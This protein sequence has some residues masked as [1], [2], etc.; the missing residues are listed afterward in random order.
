MKRIVLIGLI[1]GLGLSLMAQT[2]EQSSADTATVGSKMIYEVDPDPVIAADL[3]TLEQGITTVED[4]KKLV[5]QEDEWT[6]KGDKAI[7]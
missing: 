2:M 7:Q 5:T 3:N 4:L 6:E 1:S